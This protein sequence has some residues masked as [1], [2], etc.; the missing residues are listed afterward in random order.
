MR[1]D[2][3]ASARGVA[4]FGMGRIMCGGCHLRN[5]FARV[6]GHVFQAGGAG[7]THHLRRGRPPASSLRTGGAE[8]MRATPVATMSGRP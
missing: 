2:S 1:L 7:E 3:R 6:S 8:S 5:L 4:G